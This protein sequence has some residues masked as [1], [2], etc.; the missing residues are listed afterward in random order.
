MDRKKKVR[1]R[2]LRKREQRVA[3]HSLFLI[4]LS[5]C[6]CLCLGRPAAFRRQAVPSSEEVRKRDSSNVSARRNDGLSPRMKQS[7]NARSHSLFS[8]SIDERKSISAVFFF[9]SARSP[10]SLS[11]SLFNPDLLASFP[12]FLSRSPSFMTTRSPTSTTRTSAAST[13]ARATR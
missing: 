11:L 3:P 6:P 12:F 5:I 13:T 2:E 8:P 9:S 10:L 1:T 7:A 4:G